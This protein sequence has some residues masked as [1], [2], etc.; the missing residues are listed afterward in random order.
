MARSKVKGRE[1]RRERANER[2]EVA[3]NRT[4]EE[5]LKRLDQ[6]FGKDQGA[7]KERLKLKKRIEERNR[8]SVQAKKKEGPEEEK[9]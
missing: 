3:A 5:Q 9:K 8:I 6:K 2:A 1:E 4:P 7:S